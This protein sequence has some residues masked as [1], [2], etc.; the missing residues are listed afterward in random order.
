[1]HQRTFK[2][3]KKFPLIVTVWDKDHPFYGV[4]CEWVGRSG[5]FL[6][7]EYDGKLKLVRYKN[8]CIGDNSSFGDE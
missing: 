3:N 8:A 6:E 4:A 1:M 2:S 5:D 7:V